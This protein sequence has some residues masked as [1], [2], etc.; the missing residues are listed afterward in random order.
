MSYLFFRTVHRYSHYMHLPNWKSISQ[1]ITLGDNRNSLELFSFDTDAFPTLAYTI[2][3]RSGLE[4]CRIWKLYEEEINKR[5]MAG[6]GGNKGN[7]LLRLAPLSGSYIIISLRVLWGYQWHESM[8]CSV[9]SVFF[10]LWFLWRHG[11]VS[12]ATI[13]WS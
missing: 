12:V 2:R 5:N 11:I 1:K 4:S 8:R 13:S 7:L 3:L 9:V 6:E 10:C